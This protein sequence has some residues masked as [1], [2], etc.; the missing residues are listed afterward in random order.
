[1]VAQMEIVLIWLAF[2]FLFI[3]IGCVLSARAR[4]KAAT[5]REVLLSEPRVRSGAGNNVRMS[6]Y[7]YDGLPPDQEI[8]NVQGAL[9]RLGYYQYA[10]DGCSVR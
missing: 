5:H 9:Q 6:I 8:A 7:G 4:R 2:T 3:L 10:V 1:M